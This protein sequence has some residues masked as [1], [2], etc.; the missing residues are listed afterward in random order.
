M[1]EQRL[2]SY[3]CVAFTDSHRCGSDKEKC[4]SAA[5]QELD[6]VTW[7]NPPRDWAPPADTWKRFRD[8]WEEIKDRD[9]VYVTQILQQE[10]RKQRREESQSGDGDDFTAKPAQTGSDF[11]CCSRQKIKT[12]DDQL[13]SGNIWTLMEFWWFLVFSDHEVETWSF[14]AEWAIR[15]TVTRRTKNTKRWKHHWRLVF[16]GPLKWP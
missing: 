7:L 9:D 4:Q 5:A 2:T 13:T 14:R 10:S 15:K 3:W 11:K 1:G 6:D 8:I 12:A 16:R